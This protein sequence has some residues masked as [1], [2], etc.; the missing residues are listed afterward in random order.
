MEWG[1]VG[2]GWRGWRLYEEKHMDGGGHCLAVVLGSCGVIQEESHRL[3][4]IRTPVSC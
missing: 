2:V 1:G 4:V 3:F